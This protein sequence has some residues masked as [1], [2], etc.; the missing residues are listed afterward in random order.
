VARLDRIAD[1]KHLGVGIYTPT[2]AAQF[3]G[4]RTQQILRWVHG[5]KQG[6]PVVSAQFPGDR[7]YLTFIDMVQA[8]AFKAM[9]ARKIPLVRIR[10]AAKYVEKRYPEL[11]FPFAYMHRTYII[12]ATRQIVILRPGDEKDFVQVSGH[13]KGQLVAEKILDEYMQRL[14]F[15]EE[16]R[17]VR[18]VPL[19]VGSRSIVL[20][21]EIRSGQP[22]VWPCGYL[23][24][25]LVSAC[26]AE[27]SIK[28]AAWAYDVKPDDVK[29]A[30]KY[31]KGL[32]GR[33]A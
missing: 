10:D 26:H 11:R 19:K 13:N 31:E 32:R 17:A 24:E 18:F 6:Q 25:T 30:L 9:R 21:P 20:D 2:E 4:V 22:R 3:V 29:I 27:R 12:E 16:G 14:E 5:N 15:D 28:G 8:M 23:V 1:E 33:A 7:D